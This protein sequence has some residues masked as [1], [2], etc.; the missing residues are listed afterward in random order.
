MVF[1]HRHE[2]IGEASSKLIK[3]LPGEYTERI[4]CQQRAVGSMS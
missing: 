4:R 3:R 2:R 1:G